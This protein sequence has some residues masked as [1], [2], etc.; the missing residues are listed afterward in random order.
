MDTHEKP[1]EYQ[2]DASS[3]LDLKENDALDKTNGKTPD[4]DALNHSVRDGTSPGLFG[5][6][7]S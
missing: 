4:L 3:R 5:S 2:G 1:V 6:L 7:Y